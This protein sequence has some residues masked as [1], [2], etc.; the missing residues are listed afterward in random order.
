[1]D[2]NNEAIE[3][4][5]KSNLALS[6]TVLLLMKKLNEQKKN[7][8][9]DIPSTQ[10]RGNFFDD[11][12]VID[13]V[14]NEDYVNNENNENESDE[15]YSEYEKPG[16]SFVDDSF[17]SD[18][19]ESGSDSDYKTFLERT[20]SIFEQHKKFIK[21]KK[22]KKEEDEL[23]LYLKDIVESMSKWMIEEEIER[24]L[25][26]DN[27]RYKYIVTDDI[28]NSIISKDK[29][30]GL[31]KYSKDLYKAILKIRKSKSNNGDDENKKIQKIKN[32]F[33]EI[34]GSI[35]ARTEPNEKL[36]RTYNKDGKI[37]YNEIFK[38]IEKSGNLA[39]EDES[40]E[41]YG[42]RR[43][44]I[45]QN[46]QLM[47][48]QL[49]NMV[50]KALDKQKTKILGKE[51]DLKPI[52]YTILNQIIYPLYESTDN[53]SVITL[54]DNLLFTKDDTKRGLLNEITF[55][56]ETFFV[57]ALLKK[58]PNFLFLKFIKDEKDELKLHFYTMSPQGKR[59]NIFY[60]I[61]K[62]PTEEKYDDLYEGAYPNSQVF[63]KKLPSAP[64]KKIGPPSG[65]P[66]Y[67]LLQRDTR[68]VRKINT[69][70]V[71]N[72]SSKTFDKKDKMWKVNV[73][74]DTE[75]N[76]EKDQNEENKYNFERD[77]AAVGTPKV[78]FGEV[79][80]TSLEL[81]DEHLDN[82]PPEDRRRKP[83]RKEGSRGGRGKKKTRK[84]RKRN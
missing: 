19:S 76:L 49:H 37:N 77:Y 47:Y 43:E 16:D 40:T 83:T 73:E 32:I 24:N 84:N 31:E 29:N 63:T 75:E 34:M 38:F 12:E 33:R 4:T 5:G 72:I 2:N 57:K 13:N 69:G 48:R 1:M 30:E 35:T 28:I 20:P 67:Q 21:I 62:H 26:R 79:V 59:I 44:K 70:D 18:E 54:I 71:K 80:D 41:S 36:N 78:N 64:S 11:E 82:K 23:N 8:I 27:I 22:E 58:D 10:Q 51:E 7:M 42:G 65:K 52:L 50:E 56:K 39:T 53:K 46:L 14:D 81:A 55:G 61:K 15:L 17:S 68:Q 45:K 60:L 9:E 25:T 74:E 6:A 3:N 66:P